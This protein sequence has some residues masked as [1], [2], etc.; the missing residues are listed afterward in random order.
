MVFPALISLAMYRMPAVLQPVLNLCLSAN[1]VLINV[2]FG[3]L[4]TQG[5]DEIDIT[6]STNEVR[7]KIV[8]V[9]TRGGFF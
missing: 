7:E 5:M 1:P 2:I 3:A 9:V 4:I 6:T 8:D